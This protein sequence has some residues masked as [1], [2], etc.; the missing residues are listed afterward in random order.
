MVTNY[1]QFWRNNFFFKS[2]LT[3]TTCTKNKEFIC[4]KYVSLNFNVNTLC[5][6]N[7]VELIFD[8]RTKN[9]ADEF[10]AF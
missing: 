1:L 10:S 5:D 9:Q 6:V 8:F 3:I 2:F 7:R 4:P